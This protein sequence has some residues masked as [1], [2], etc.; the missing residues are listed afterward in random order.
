MLATISKAI[1]FAFAAVLAA[2]PNGTSQSFASPAVKSGWQLGPFVR[3]TEG[4]PVIRPNPKS[5]FLDPMRK[6]SVAWEALHTFN[7]AAIVRNGKVVVLYRAED[8][9]GTMAIG[10]HTSRLG[11]AES[12]DG[13]HFTRRPAPVFFPAP[14]DQTTREWEGGVEDPRIVESEDGTYVITYTQWNRVTYS[15]GIATSRDLLTWHKYGPALGTTGKYGAL[16]Y[17]SGAIITSLNNGRLIAA[18]I[19]G[20]YWMY[21]GEGEVHVASSTDLIHWQPVEDAA[22]NA[23]GVLGPRPG[24]FDSHF[25]ETGAP[26]VITANG[27]VFLYNGKNAT[28]ADRDAA[29][30]P[31][32]YAAGQALFATDDPTKLLDRT[33]QPFFKPEMPFEKN[34]QYVAGTTFVEGLVYFHNRWIIY[35]GGADSLVGV[36]MT[37]PLPQTD[38]VSVKPKDGKQP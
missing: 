4:N 5:I 6:K 28:D 38:A 8:D 11:L 12:D 36:A 24:H 10:M 20:K 19:Q 16:K 27:I 34:G 29:L 31:N 13:I 35:Y 21:W 18:R 14:D 37:T 30:D 2:S 17:K 9:S 7:P 3:P 25:P 23:I 22:G 26:P 33:E 15:I 1:V 32:A